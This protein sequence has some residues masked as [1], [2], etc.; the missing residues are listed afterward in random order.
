MKNQRTRK[1]TLGD[2]SA[3]LMLADSIDWDLLDNYFR[4]YGPGPFTCSEESQ[5]FLQ[6][7]F[8][9]SEFPLANGTEIPPKAEMVKPPKALLSREQ[10]QGNYDDLLGESTVHLEVLKSIDRFAKSSKP[11]LISGETGTGKELVARALH[12]ESP[13]AT[14]RLIIVNCAEFAENLIENELFGHEKGAFTGADQLHKGLF[15]TASGG[16]LFLDEIGELPMHLQP[17]LLRVLQENEIRR[18]GGT[19]QIPVSVRVLAATN[20]D[21]AEAVAAGKFRRDLYERLKPLHIQLPALRERREDI[22]ALAKHFLIKENNLSNQKVVDIHPE[23]LSLLDAYSWSGNIREL[24]GVI[25]YA[26]LLAEEGDIL[27]H[28]LPPDLWTPQVHALPSTDATVSTNPNA[29]ECFVLTF[30]IGTPL[31]EIVKSAILETLARENGNKSK[32]AEV[33]RISRPTLDA[34][35]NIYRAEGIELTQI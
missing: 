2:V 6:K 35:L 11:V 25:G 13:Y 24:E 32:T 4:H 19:K 34:K 14:S 1:S 12:T 30:P 29:P 20:T 31:Q 28:H 17:K 10:L 5:P 3:S 22:P 15:E 18:V 21:L 23:V 16:T 33:L 27:P 26:V 9:S 7:A 8:S